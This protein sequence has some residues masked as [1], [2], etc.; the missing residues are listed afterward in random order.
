MGSAVLTEQNNSPSKLYSDRDTVRCRV[1]SVLRSIANDGC[2][3]E[4][5]GDSELVGAD[6]AASDPLWG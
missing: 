1:V 6:D 5:D 3:Q 2:K 4:T